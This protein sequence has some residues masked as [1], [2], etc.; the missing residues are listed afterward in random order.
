MLKLQ[1]IKKYTL[2]HYFGHNF[3]SK[4]IIL[5]ID[6]MLIAFSLILSFTL[7]SNETLHKISVIDYYK[8]LISVIIFSILGHYIF[9]PHRGIIRHTSLHDV[10]RV[11]YARS[12]SFGCN[13]V[14]I[15]LLSDKLNLKDY[16]L[17]FSVAAINYFLSLYL[18]IQ[19][20][21]AI[22][23]TFNLGRKTKVKSSIL[24]Y[25]AGRA[26]QLTYDALESF[27][28]IVGFVDDNFTKRGKMYKGVPIYYYNDNI[29]EI[30]QKKKITQIVISIQNCSLQ[31]KRTIVNRSIEW[32]LEVK[33]VPPIDQWANGE[34]TKSQIKV[35]KIED[36]LG[37]ESIELDRE[38]LKGAFHN[39]TILI[40]GAAGS[41]GSE[42]SRQLM[43]YKPKKIILVDQAE[44]PLHHL[45]IELS[46]SY[47]YGFTDM[48]TIL[49][50]IK[51]FKTMENLFQN[52]EINYVYHAAAYK[53]VPAMEKNP[54]QAVMVNLLGTKNIVDLCDKYHVEKMV[55]IST[56]KAV[57]PT[58]VMGATKRAA[59][60]Y[61][62]SKNVHSHTSFITTRFGNV[63]GSNG[64]VIPLFNK[65][66]ASGGPLTVTHP[67][68]TRY[69]MTIP[70]ACQLVL[71]AGYMGKGGEI[72]VFD[73]GESIK[74]VDLAIK[75]IQL[76]G[77]VPERDIKIQYT[78]LRPGEKLFEELLNDKELVMPT[79]HNKI[80]IAKM[81]DYNYREINFMF[82]EIEDL[83]F[84]NLGNRAVVS[85]LKQLVPEF[86]SKN[87]VFEDLDQDYS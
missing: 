86:K 47:E 51:D 48:V 4:W 75:M 67:E 10:K 54:Q 59:E 3:V 53:H 73:M 7:L 70:E 19:F 21:L 5:F 64:S 60:M 77:L 20:R 66:I 55:F 18:L 87:S 49:A 62:Q 33:A 36:L 23:Y 22:K 38:H 34:L 17:P 13:I 9:K 39:K 27:Y 69:F 8:G 2:I 28:N 25:G 76:S 81:I 15:L 46:S 79:H 30:I 50:D 57:N 72:F 43:F 16:A 32:N 65:Q 6:L 78:G 31:E 52:N 35:V 71:E 45:E 74:I 58:N 56:D 40:T 68:I 14:F 29:L 61:V 83:I 11:L 80:M 24:I 63:L 41:I 44:T 85:C 82:N 1:A 42:L 37:R 26:G 12:F 84:N